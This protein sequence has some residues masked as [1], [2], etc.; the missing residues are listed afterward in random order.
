[1][2]QVRKFLAKF[3]LKKISGG[4]MI[5]FGFLLIVFTG[6]L[7]L[8]LPICSQNRVWTPFID[9]LF[10]STSAVCVTGL[11]VVPTGTYWSLL[12]QIVIM[13]LIQIGGLGFMTYMTLLFVA[14]G[15]RITIHD[16]LLIQSSINSDHI[17]G[18][19]RFVRRIAWYVF[20]IECVGA[21]CLWIVFGPQY[22]I[23]LGLYYGIFHSISMY[24]NAGFDLMAAQGQSSFMSYVNNTWVTLVLSLLIII[25]GLGFSV[26]INLQDYFLDKY[27]RNKRPHLVVHTKAVLITTGILLLGGTILFLLFEFNN[28]DTLGNLPWYGKLNAAFFQATTPRTAGANTIDQAKLTQPSLFLTDVLMFIGASPGSTGGGLKTTTIFVLFMTVWS[29]LSGDRE[30]NVMKRRIPFETIKRAM[31]IFFIAII[32]LTFSFFLLM[33]FEPD[34]TPE[35][36]LFELLSAYNTVGLSTG[37]TSLLCNWSKI[38]L[39]ASMFIGRVGLLTIVYLLS[40]TE[41]KSRMNKGNYK[42][43]KTS[44]LLG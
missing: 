32:Y 14:T 7:I 15:R 1:M 29:V 39:I 21:F 28:P 22:G 8:T 23:G 16:R 9:A 38:V 41:R 6:A 19:V 42:L 44:I 5:V 33:L 18:I 20:V 12:G 26:Y 25:G 36:L 10:T 24:C 40:D 17:T 11:I 13:L 4:Q 37:I 27:K 2:Y 43:P 30:V 3:N 31:V 35:S 34:L